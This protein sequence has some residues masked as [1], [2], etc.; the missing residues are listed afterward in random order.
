MKPN[1]SRVIICDEAF[2]LFNTFLFNILLFNILLH[3]ILILF[4]T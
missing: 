3:I 2:Y 1:A 4:V